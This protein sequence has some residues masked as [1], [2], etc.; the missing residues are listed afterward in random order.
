VEKCQICD[1]PN[2]EN[3]LFLGYLPAVNTMYT[4][5]ERLHEQPSYP[6]QILYCPQCYLVQLGL[7]VDAKILFHPQ[8]PYT[9]ST[10][11]ILRDNFAELYL[12][13]KTIINLN[14]F[15]LIVDIGSN[16]GNL[17][18]NFKENHRVLGITPEKIGNIAIER[19]I[20]PE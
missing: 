7:I 11:K 18:S 3:V 20:P 10:T 17:L 12:E 6:T 19:G 16:D 8:Y 9:S 2:L 15:N 5:G 1:N 14:K 4:V 13:S